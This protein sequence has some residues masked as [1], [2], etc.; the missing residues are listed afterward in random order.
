MLSPA[1]FYFSLLHSTTFSGISR[2]ARHPFA[3]K[4]Y[5]LTVVAALIE[6]EGKLLICQ[7]RRG[8]NFE[9]KWEFPGGKVK[10]RESLPQALLRELQEE[11]DIDAAI[12]HELFRAQH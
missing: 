11:L 7:R 8:S 5:M 3:D 4:A 1:R 10:P 9:L 12:G 2:L 6:S